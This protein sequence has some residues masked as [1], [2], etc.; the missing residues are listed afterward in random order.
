M[1]ISFCSLTLYNSSKLGRSAN[2][3]RRLSS[4][5]LQIHSGAVTIRRMRLFLPKSAKSQRTIRLPR[6]SGLR[7]SLYP[8]YRVPPIFSLSGKPHPRPQ[9]YNPSRT[10]FSANLC[11]R[12]LKLK[13]PHSTY[14]ASQAALARSK[15]LRRIISLQVTPMLPRVSRCRQRASSATQNPLKLSQ[16]HRQTSLASLRLLNKSSNPNLRVCLATHL[17][18]SRSSHLHKTAKLSNIK[19]RLLRTNGNRLPTC[20][21]RIQASVRHDH[22]KISLDLENRILSSNF[23]QMLIHP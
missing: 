5:C 13:S 8:I 20:G 16:T 10:T 23:K 9:K 22:L 18:P 4:K 7:R 2:H 3:R 19:T 12:L 11:L 14:L 6:S 21:V 17:H 1:H 15:H